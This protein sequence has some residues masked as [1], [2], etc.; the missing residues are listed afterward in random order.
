MTGG[1]RSQWPSLS[2]DCQ[3]HIPVSPSVISSR[4]SDLTAHHI[5]FPRVLQ[6]QHM[7]KESCIFRNLFSSSLL[8]LSTWS[9]HFTRF[10]KLESLLMTP[11][12]FWGLSHQFLLFLESNVS[13]VPSLLSISASMIITV[14]ITLHLRNCYGPLSDLPAGNHSTLHPFSLGLAKVLR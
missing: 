13:W 1:E 14:I 3:S 6:T 9:Y 10:P 2:Y 8:R 5:S 11:L 12:T 7:Q 4:P